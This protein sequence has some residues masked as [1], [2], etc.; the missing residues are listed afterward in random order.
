MANPLF[1]PEVRLML[2]ENDDA[3]I[4][5]FCES[6]HPAT[7][8]E[9]LAEEVSVEDAWRFLS[10]TDIRTQAAIFEYFPLDWQVKMVEGTGQQQ[11]ARLIEQMSHD[12]RV[13]LV[14][15]LRPRIADGL[16]R[17]VDD[18]DRKDI[19][20]LVAQ[21]PETAGALMTTDY[22]WAP[23]NVTVADTFDR[24]R[25]QAPDSETIYY[26]YI[27][28]DQRTLL[29]VITLRQM[30][31][32]PRH[33]FLRDVMEH[34]VVK[35]ELG[36]DQKKVSDLM[37]R[38]DLIAIPVVDSEG[39]MVGIVT[40]DDVIDVVVKEAT[41]D[42]LKFG[43]VGEGALDQPYFDMPFWAMVKKR[44]GWLIVLFLGEMLTATA[45]G[46]FEKE[47]ER[48]VVLALFIPL[49]I[50]SGGNSG[51][52]AATIIIRAMALGEVRLRQWWSVMRREIYSGL[53]LGAVL[54]SIGF[55]R[56]GI[57][58]LIAD[59]FGKHAYGEHWALVGL[60][61]ACS[62][63]GVVLWGTLS[64]SMLPL[65]LRRLGFDPATSSAP[66]VATLV[67]VTGLIIYFTVAVVILHK[68][69]L[70]PGEPMPDVIVAIEADGKLKID[71]QPTTPE[72]F[73]E[74]LTPIL[75]RAEK[76]TARLLVDP[77]MVA[78]RLLKIFKEI[79]D[80][81]AYSVQ[82]RSAAA[83]AAP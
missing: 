54:G 45:M 47:I 11:M 73:G 77:S 67:D 63:V 15:R 60:T 35:V 9:A 10:R 55:M 48:A 23:A 46:Y 68:T 82:L 78:P 75:E 71:D 57:W 5:A 7:V 83:A 14:R 66:F 24:L 3:E 58:S 64:G 44:G 4:R 8:A 17:L 39:R 81:G 34:N 61:V 41:Q 62:L 74:R 27:L 1:A 20:T 70:A 30:V 19:A 31:L 29:G 59:F 49:I 51:S 40:H 25:L 42:A 26:V 38:Y 21:K 69:L 16:L 56:I 22:A 52:Q 32:A 37:A 2:Q 65:I 18:A 28:D 79:E 36:D 80:A 72:E 43:A 53:A 6:L 50:S 76:K 12:D 33:A 13:D